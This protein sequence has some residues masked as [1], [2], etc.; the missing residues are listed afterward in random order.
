MKHALSLLT[1][2]GLLLCPVAAAEKEAPA[3]RNEKASYS[4]GLNI[5]RDFKNRLFDPD[6]DFLVKGVQ[7]ALAER[8]P[9]ISEDES[10]QVL[11][12]LQAELKSKADEKRKEQAAKNQAEGEAFLAANKQKPGVVTLPSGL[13]YTVLEEG[14]GPQPGPEDT[15]TVHYHGTLIDGT[16][17]DSSY[18]REQPATFTPARVI[19]GWREALQLM[20]VGSKWQLFIPSNLAYGETGGGR[21]IGPNAT[22]IFEVELMDTAPPVT[23]ARE[24]VTSDI[25]KVPSKEELERGAQIQIIK[26]EELEKLK[27]Q[28]QQEKK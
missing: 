24:P 16:V 1:V 12:Q 28:Q 15:V 5:G 4:I 2:A 9:L 23:A 11:S 3:S 27:Q 8:D 21:A 26:P 22:L 20:P 17:F 14:T 25:I 10:R 7:D 19:P 13:Q 18:D 6:L